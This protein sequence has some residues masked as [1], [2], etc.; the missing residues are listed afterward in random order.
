MVVIGV[1]DT[2]SR[3]GG[4]CTTWIGTEIVRRLPPG[5]V[6]RTRLVRLNPAIEHKTRGNGAVAIETSADPVVAR[7]VA[8]AVIDEWAVTDDPETNP[9]LVVIP[10]ERAHAGAYRSLAHRA[11]RSTIDRNTVDDLLASDGIATRSWGNGR[12][13]I[14]AT[15]AVGAVGA[16]AAREHRFRDWTYEWLVYRERERWGTPRDVVRPS[17][18]P[19][20]AAPAVWDTIDPVTDELTCVPHSPCPVLFGIRGD[21]PNRVRTVGERMGGEP[22]ARSRLFVTN[23][24]T[25]AHLRPG[26]SGNLVDG[27]CYRVRG[28]VKTA[29]ET[30]RGGHVAVGLDVAD[31]TL[32]CLAFAPTGRFRDHVRDLVPGDDVLACGEFADGSLKLE[33]FALVDPVLSR[34]VP[35]TCPGCD[36]RMKSAG[37]GQGYRCRACGHDR[38]GKILVPI[39]RSIERGWYEVPPGA[40]RHLAAPLVRGTYDLPVHPTTG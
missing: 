11:V 32:R 36:R 12:G 25:D 17:G 3:T 9:G 8:E 33:K 38:P 30:R 28:T 10:H 34:R 22:P 21:D 27:A 39:D 31:G 37:R 40:R 7:A 23:Q 24:G 20:A 35:P 13:L 1:D 18:Q 26:R 5:S 4:M 16:S 14:G 6:E 2:D 29:P 19:D 15:A